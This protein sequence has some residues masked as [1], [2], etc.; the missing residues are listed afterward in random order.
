M[1]EINP[2][3]I[4]PLELRTREN[5][6]LSISLEQIDYVVGNTLHTKSG[7]A[8]PLDP[9][10]ALL[11]LAVV[12]KAHTTIEQRTSDQVSRLIPQIYESLLERLPEMLIR[13]KQIVE[14]LE[15]VG[16]STSEEE[17]ETEENP[18]TVTD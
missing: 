14:E 13:L 9:T 17:T 4:Q 12:E 3:L 15:E 2:M 16:E 18:F 10:S 6:H 1:N 7:V 11:Y 5:T 8:I